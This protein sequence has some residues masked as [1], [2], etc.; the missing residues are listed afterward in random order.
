[1][2]QLSFFLRC[3]GRIA[4][5]AYFLAVALLLGV[6]YWVLP[7]ID[8]WRP[9]IARHASAALDMPVSLTQVSADWKGLNPSLELTGVGL[10][11][12]QG[13]TVFRVPHIRGLISW[14]SLFQ[15]KLRFM[16][17]E[18]TGLDLTVRRDR[19]KHFWIL[20]RSFE[21]SDA[22]T[23]EIGLDHPAV[24]WL[25]KQ[26]EIM[27]HDSILRWLDESRRAPPL[28]LRHVTLK[29]RN[30]DSGHRFSL[31]ATPP[32]TVGR[33]LD[34]RGAFDPVPDDPFPGMSLQAWNGQFYMRVANMLPV[35]WKP[36]VDMPQNL[37]S[38][39]VSAEA[40]VQVRHGR[41][42]RLTSDISVMKGRWSVDST[43]SIQA[44]SARLYLDG[45]P[46]GFRQFFPKDIPGGDAA[47][48]P[49]A[50]Q[51]GH[52]LTAV[53]P[54]S[55]GPIIFRFE[56][57]ELTLR[58]QEIFE[59]PLSFS[60]VGLQ[61][62]L[63]RPAQMVQAAFSQA[64]FLNPDMDLQWSGSWRQGGSGSGGIADIRGVFRR[65][66]V[67]AIKK[68]LPST[69]NVDARE[70]MAKGLVDGQIHDA[71]VG[72]HGDL[73]HF[74]FGEHPD[75][76][77]FSLKGHYTSAI[78]DY[79]P[80]EG[81]SLGW[82]RLADM[83][84]EVTLRRA[85]LRLTADQATMWPAKSE[86]IN[87]RHID[88]HIPDIENHSVLSVQGE[89]AAQSSAYLALMTHTPL[90][91]M[92]DDMFDKTKAEGQWEVPLSL[93]IPLEDSRNTTVKGALRFAG[94]TVSL[95]P[96]M[97]AFTHVTGSLSFTDTGLSTSDLKAQLLGGPVSLNG[98]MGGAGKGLHLRGQASSAALGDYAGLHG[99]ERLQGTVSYR[100][101][102][103]RSASRGYAFSLDSDLVGLALDFPKPMGK[104]AAQ[105]MPLH[106]AW[107]SSKAGEWG[108][109][110][111]ID[112]YMKAHFL[113]RE[114][115]KVAPYFYAGAIGVNQ[116]PDVMPSGMNIDIR[117]ADI[118]IDLWEQVIDDFSTPVAKAP[119][120][121]PQR[122]LWPDLEQIR[123][124]AGSVLLRGVRL[125]QAILTTKRV[126]REKW[127]FDVSSSQT[128][129]TIF[130][131]EAQGKVAGQVDAK[132]DRLA[133][134]S[135][136]QDAAQKDANAD[137]NDDAL[138]RLSEDLDIPAVNLQV[139]H[140]K[141]YGRNLGQL[142]LV[143]INQARGEFWRLDKLS[144][145]SD[146]AE[147]TGTGS[148]RL[149][150]P[151]RGLTLD[152]R[153]D[154]KNLGQYM[155]QLGFRDIVQEGSG[156]VSGQL[157]W[158]NLPW[159]YE[160]S[161][162]NGQIQ[163]QLKDGRFSNVGSRSAR[164][165]ELLSLQSINRLAAFKLNLGGLTKNGFPFDRLQ[166]SILVKQG[167]LTTDDYRVIGP[168]GTIVIGGTTDLKTEK[169]DLRA[170]VI[171]NL[172][173][174]GAAIAAGIAINPIVG[175]GA[176][177]TQW[178][179]KAPLAAAMTVQYQVKGDWDNPVLNEVTPIKQAGQK[180]AHSADAP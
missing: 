115:K 1:M 132:F 51:T 59:Y 152:A 60:H 62:V 105:A 141:L 71:A 34:I 160:T 148:W 130:W 137:L 81:K 9:L 66:S 47:A 12:N 118:D 126:E 23:Q 154:I 50:V 67:A 6:R 16:N 44:D 171:P 121:R 123:L 86:P 95:A 37:D 65:A 96:E 163:V 87:L 144:L 30:G 49:Q 58:T 103:Q 17:L 138:S 91:G 98:A 20:G 77:D 57:N 85:D 136:A 161:D 162:L 4:L 54:D 151:D 155:D 10:G 168:V 72:L 112:K 73:E 18:V 149:N 120:V 97:P 84:G 178:F 159:K 3:L 145:I 153:S 125:D 69:V 88:A 46:A 89:T 111:E 124:Q 135:G 53:P 133:L 61:G 40:W 127:R 174:S 167:V 157:V 8:E 2:F 7:N 94:G 33:M 42:D 114:Q 93:T 129:G 5:V 22:D 108:L 80:P 165:L 13:H 100:A 116:N 75:Q 48:V 27:A 110:V 134:G 179:L 79:I 36:W 172:D 24:R 175:L 70:W 147:L 158:R 19:E 31:T 43:T 90:G 177:L 45:P 76:G 180:Q 122:P 117:L 156:T 38:G 173:V 82:P 26:H 109:S 176:F 113:H 107:A 28:V 104:R 102:V 25:L 21:V 101:L 55:N 128:A 92:L 131:R 63:S 170:V 68:Y 56:A 164:L 150:G 119:V 41:F 99:M 52:E 106:L 166:G 142:S 146:A 15:G 169:L 139:R 32:S 143:G 64:R 35:G 29:V 78:I 14:R 83:S 39:Q 74:P 11:D 140:F